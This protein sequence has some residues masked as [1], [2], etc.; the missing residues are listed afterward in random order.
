MAKS[1]RG[2]LSPHLRVRALPIDAIKIGETKSGTTIWDDLNGNIYAVRSEQ[3]VYRLLG[4][5]LPWEV[6]AA[7]RRK[8]DA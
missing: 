2:K 8:S 1:K 5:V 7:K 4:P 3:V 6:P